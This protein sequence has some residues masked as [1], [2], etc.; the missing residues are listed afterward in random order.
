MGR[1]EYTRHHALYAWKIHVG[2][3]APIWFQD[4]RLTLSPGE[5][6][7]AVVVP[8]GLPHRLGGVGWA[9]TVFG[10][11]GS[12]NTPWHTG[13]NVLAPDARTARR[14]RHMCGEL[15]ASPRIET[16]A[17]VDDLF[18]IV[19]GPFPRTIVDTRV[20]HVLR[21]VRLE[22][23]L[24]LSELATRHSVS[25]DRLSHLVKEATGLTLRKH[26]V[27][28]R[29]IGLLSQGEHHPTL[30]A[31]AASAGFADQ[32]HMTRTY[33]SYLG[34]LPSEFMGPPDVLQRW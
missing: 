32:A 5:R 18:R 25:S 10:A 8:P 23:E 4:P 3:D 7:W 27:W 6:H 2:L 17:R 28:S 19:F 29:L 30:A 31:A 11:P 13:A 24:R 16:D 1:G 15:V 9:C 14:L 22:P 12:R 21:R 33:C 34:R 20:K 26:A